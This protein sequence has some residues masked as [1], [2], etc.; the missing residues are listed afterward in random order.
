M[1]QARFH[2]Y[3]S[4]LLLALA[5]V[6]TA[7]PVV[8]LTV[9][10]WFYDGSAKW[11]W[12]HERRQPWLAMY[13]Y[14]TLPTWVMVIG[15]AV[16]LLLS[17]RVPRL[18][19]QRR[20]LVIIVLAVLLGPGLAINA[21][22]KEYWGRPRPNRVQQFDQV[23]HFHAWWQPSR[24]EGHRSFASGHVSMTFALLAGTLT[25]ESRRRRRLA[26]AAATAY[27]C[28]MIAARVVAGA[29][30]LSDALLSATLTYMIVS[31]LLAL[32]DREA[33]VGPATAESMPHSAA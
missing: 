19:R 10:S 24:T 3:L 13:E 31:L 4:L 32:P 21:G 26:T 18:I 16:L 27:G 14:G 23:E 9:A 12:V 8:D 22:L 29:H 25:I 33:N 2:L 11:P 15:A 17:L 5:A 7:P 20:R 28:I 1:P 6:L 30:W